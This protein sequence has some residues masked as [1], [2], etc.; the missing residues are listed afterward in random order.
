LRVDIGL[1]RLKRKGGLNF[2]CNYSQF[3]GEIFS[4][5]GHREHREEIEIKRLLKDFIN[6]VTSVFSV[7]RFILFSVAFPQ[8]YE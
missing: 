6:S 3:W 7:A 1:L 5:R 8:F 4:H 2:S